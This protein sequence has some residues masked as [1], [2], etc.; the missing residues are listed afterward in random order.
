MKYITVL[1]TLIAFVTATPAY[2]GPVGQALDQLGMSDQVQNAGDALQ[3]ELTAAATHGES[4]RGASGAMAEIALNSGELICNAWIISF[5][6]HIRNM[7]IDSNRMYGD[8]LNH[9]LELIQKAQE[10]VSQ[11]E[12]ECTRVG[13]IGDGPVGGNGN[14]NGEDGPDSWDGEGEDTDGDGEADGPAI[15]PLPG[16]TIAD[17]ICRHR[18]LDEYNEWQK[19][20]RWLREDEQAKRDA[21]EEV[22][23]TRERL[24]HKERELADAEAER[25]RLRDFLMTP[26]G[27]RISHSERQEMIRSHRRLSYLDR[28]KLPRLR[29]DIERLR[30][31]LQQAQRFA[32]IM[33]RAV[34][35]RRTQEAAARAAYYACLRHC[36]QQAED[37]GEETTIDVPN[38][39]GESEGSS[40]SSS[41]SSSSSSGAASASTSSSSSGS[42]SGNKKIIKDNTGS[43]LRNLWK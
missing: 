24:N 31:D 41:S 37:A 28:Y 20:L 10:F 23:R 12:R 32:D 9:Q 25:T 18:C 22:R 5:H 27:P 1:L 34:E 16:E 14:G 26:H 30:Q 36:L 7:I 17:A 42:G 3:Q 33:Q 43:K 11:L 35:H 39:N 6:I 21:D 29:R 4:V 40:G 19:Q 38:E 2:A 8:R 13:L 15:T